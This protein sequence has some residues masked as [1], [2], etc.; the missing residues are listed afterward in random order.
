[1]WRL[2]KYDDFLEDSAREGLGTPGGQLARPSVINQHELPRYPL[3]VQLL[4]KGLGL[5]FQ[6]R[7]KVSPETQGQAQKRGFSQAYDR[8]Q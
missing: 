6:V 7:T 1:M 3:C 2:N 8:A 4:G 5:Q